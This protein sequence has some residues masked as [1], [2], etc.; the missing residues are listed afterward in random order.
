M[1]MVDKVKYV[2]LC[3]LFS[4]ILTRGQDS[5]N[6]IA[7]NYSGYLK[8]T[9]NQIYQYR[10]E[11]NTSWEWLHHRLNLRYDVSKRLSFVSEFRTRIFQGQFV[12]E[13]KSFILQ[14]NNPNDAVCLNKSWDINESMVLLTRIDRLSG[15]FNTDNWKIKAGRQRINWGMATIWNTNDIFNTYNFLDIDYLER[16]SADGIRINRRIGDLSSIE[17]AY[18]TALK[19]RRAITALRYNTNLKGYDI[20]F[21][22]GKYESRTTA[23]VG[24]SG[25]IGN[26]GF[27]GEGQFY[28]SVNSGSVLNLC[29]EG[30]YLFSGSWY[31]NIA[32]LYCSAGQ[33]TPTKESFS[34]ILQI[35]P[36]QPMP[37]RWNYAVCIQKNVWTLWNLSSIIFFVPL[38]DYLI[39]YPTV[40]YDAG[41]RM[42][43]GLSL[44]SVLNTSE[45]VG[46][47]SANS[48]FASL[49]WSY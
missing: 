3:L 14:V 31:L 49:K 21:N 37:F 4:G 45:G 41:K 6:T 23:G 7:F 32:G 16:S 2:V 44:Q 5:T 38:S 22:A 28:S 35:I 47:F 11:Q 43:I 15:E 48:C 13:N 27:R 36:I 29:I 20:S 42:D 17:V 33:N 26:C 30:D 18:S 34:G 12:R 46:L 9:G 10:S 25:N 8:Y 39:F 24:W 1:N 19:N 40:T